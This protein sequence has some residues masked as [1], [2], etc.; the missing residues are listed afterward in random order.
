MEDTW[1]IVDISVGTEGW[2]TWASRMGMSLGAISA[3]G[4]SLTQA[5]GQEKAGSDR[6]RDWLGEE[7]S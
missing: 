6:Q 2:W 5:G 7:R 4:L 3:I 1:H